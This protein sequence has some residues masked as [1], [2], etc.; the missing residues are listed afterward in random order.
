[1]PS[2][3][4]SKG[5]GIVKEESERAKMEVQSGRAALQRRVTAKNSN[6]L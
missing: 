2:F 5:K 3:N 1:M 6:G 4:T